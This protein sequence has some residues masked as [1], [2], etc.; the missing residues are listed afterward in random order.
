MKLQFISID[1]LP[2]QSSD[3]IRAKNEPKIHHLFAKP[4]LTSG[5]QTDE[6]LINTFDQQFSCNASEC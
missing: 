2:S 1:T 3:S 5:N 6:K 4:F